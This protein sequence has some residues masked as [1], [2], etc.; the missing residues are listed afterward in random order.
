MYIELPHNVDTMPRYRY[1]PVEITPHDFHRHR[2]DK[3]RLMVDNP[4]INAAAR[5]EYW[6]YGPISLFIPNYLYDFDSAIPS[7]CLYIKSHDPS[8]GSKAMCFPAVILTDEELTAL[9]R[10]RYPDDAKDPEVI[11]TALELYHYHT[12]GTTIHVKIDNPS[13]ELMELF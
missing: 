2:K 11:A 4:T 6:C 10:M 12:N 3:M 7:L 1:V 9:F 5:E 8:F 13:S